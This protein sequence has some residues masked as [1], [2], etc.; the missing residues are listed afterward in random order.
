MSRSYSVGSR[1]DPDVADVELLLP[2]LPTLICP[3]GRGG[4]G[5][6]QVEVEVDDVDGREE[7]EPIV[8]PDVGELRGAGELM[9]G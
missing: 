4:L 8:A 6:V 5:R 9:S 3:D 7:V 1:C 2:V